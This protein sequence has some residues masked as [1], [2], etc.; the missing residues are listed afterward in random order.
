MLN[1]LYSSGILSHS[2]F[3]DL[4]GLYRLRNIIVHG[5]SVPEIG[6]GAVTFL[7][8]TARRLLEES[9]PFEPVS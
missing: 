8:D 7:S 9:R 4:E 3:R 1:D 6:H 5:F 2:E